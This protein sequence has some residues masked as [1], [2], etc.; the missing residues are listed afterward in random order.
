VAVADALVSID[1]TWLGLIENPVSAHMDY[2]AN[3]GV[4]ELIAC[5]FPKMAGCR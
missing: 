1:T 5:G 2:L 3:P 4:A